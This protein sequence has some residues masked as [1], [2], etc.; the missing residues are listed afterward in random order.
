[1]P[2]YKEEKSFS[3][4]HRFSPWNKLTL[5]CL[6]DAGNRTSHMLCKHSTTKLH[7]Q[8]CDTFSIRTPTSA[9]S[10]KDLTKLRYIGR[11]EVAKERTPELLAVAEPSVSPGCKTTQ[12]YSSSCMCLLYELGLVILVFSF[13]LQESALKTTKAYTNVL[14]L[15]YFFPYDIL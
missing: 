8:P 13:L 11:A 4:L 7:Y 9:A 1:M 14:F 12:Y 5:C 3:S 2:R 15:S 10:H 6:C